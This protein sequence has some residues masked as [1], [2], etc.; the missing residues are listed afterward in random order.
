MRQINQYIV[1][2]LLKPEEFFSHIDE[3]LD[4]L[5]FKEK[6]HKFKNTEVIEDCGFEDKDGFTYIVDETYKW[7]CGGETYKWN[8]GDEIYDESYQNF[9]Y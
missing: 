3:W 6:D 5:N 7:D 1:R 2:C 9:E 8:S 4:T